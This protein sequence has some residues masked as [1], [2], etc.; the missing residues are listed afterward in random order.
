VI[1]D[2]GVE[3][4]AID[5]AV[6]QVTPPDAAVAK[7]E[8][9]TV[10]VDANTDGAVIYENGKKLD[11]VPAMIKVTPGEKRTLV[12]KKKGYK[13]TTV[14]VDG[15]QNKVKVSLDRVG[16][17]AGSGKGTGAGTGKGTGGGTGGGTSKPPEDPRKKL[18]REHPDDPRCMLEP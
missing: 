11:K 15:G 18:C 4:V 9:I 5:A 17:G 2:A 10:L 16:G 12:L 8:P 6:A 1:V 3:P 14:V 13:D 7:V